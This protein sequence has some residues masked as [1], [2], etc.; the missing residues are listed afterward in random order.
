MRPITPTVY[1][2]AEPGWAAPRWTQWLDILETT[3]QIL[4]VP[5]FY[6][7]LGIRLIETPKVYLGD[8]GLACH[9]TPTVG[10]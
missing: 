3:G 4:V 8:S 7:N 1:G 2:P 9:L 5:P 6:E 10:G